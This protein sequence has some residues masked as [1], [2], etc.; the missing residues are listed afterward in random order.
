LI[1]REN[2]GL[3]ATLNQALSILDDTEYFAYLGSDDVWLDTFLAA[4]IEV[5]KNRSGAVLGYGH[6]YLIDEENKVVDCT[7]EWA[8][9]KDG[10]VRDMLLETI[11]PMSPTV[12]YRRDS[13]AKYGWN[14]NAR[15]EDYELYLRLSLD[16][17][18]AFDPRILS[19]WRQ[20]GENTSRNQQMMLEEQIAA[21]KVVAPGFGIGAQDLDRLLKA[22]RFSRAED[23]LRVGDKRKAIELVVQNLN[24]VDRSRLMPIVKRLLIPY[25][26]VSWWK[27]KKQSKASERY[28]SL[29]I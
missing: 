8:D 26:A 12:L 20:H 7:A 22:I 24:A 15:L 3:T 14:E 21:L 13:L 11:G 9:Y 2:R 16:G 4:R 27:R 17:E 5:L 23:F 1:A 18:F 19:A 25:A 6:S 29:K 10:D 28:G